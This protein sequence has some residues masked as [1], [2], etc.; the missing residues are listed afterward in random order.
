MVRALAPALFVIGVLVTGCGGSHPT[1][2]EADMAACTNNRDD[3]NDGLVDCHDSDC[4]VF[5]VCR[6]DAGVLDADLDAPMS[7]AGPCSAPLDIVLVVDVSTS[8]ASD[9]AAI[10]AGIG[11]VWDAAHALTEDTQISM[12]VFVDDVLAVDASQ[13]P[14]ST[15][16]HC[17]PFASASDIETHLVA[18][19]MFCATNQSPVSHIQNHDCAENSLDA[20]MVATAC[21][22]RTGSTR[23]ILHV[24]DDTFAERPAVLSGAFG[25]G[26]RVQFNFV[27]TLTM[28]TDHQYHVGVFAESGVGDDC[29]AGRSPD[30]GRGFS[31][32][33]GGMLSLPDATG[34]HFWDLRQVRAGNIDM[35]QTIGDFL[36]EVYCGP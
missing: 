35:T 19:Q 26:V 2:T 34:G 18:W 33:Y 23:V 13:P 17:V 5:Q 27:E 10:R 7:D 3:D 11:S 1:P 25:G 14:L 12:V 31:G 24:T 15:G 29:G 4:A 30:V 28:L 8:M 20:I 9:I 32:P 21:P 16:G 36:R 6:H 22:V